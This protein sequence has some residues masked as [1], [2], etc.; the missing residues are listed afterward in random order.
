MVNCMVAEARCRGLVV[1]EIRMDTETYNTFVKHV[2]TGWLHKEVGGPVVY[3]GM[4]LRSC[5]GCGDVSIK[6]IAKR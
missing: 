2:E 1:S 6:I 5:A 4:S 3:D